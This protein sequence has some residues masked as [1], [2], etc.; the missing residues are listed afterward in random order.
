M[1]A[2]QC[3]TDLHSLN[4]KFLL[5]LFLFIDQLVNI[6]KL[7]IS[8][9]HRAFYPNKKKEK[10]SGCIPNLFYRLDV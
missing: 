8:T 5:F 1:A 3:E 10:K 2:P 6:L 9:I 4:A 7:V